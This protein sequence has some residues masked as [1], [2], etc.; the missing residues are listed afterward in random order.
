ME[1]AHRLQ[2]REFAAKD[3]FVSIKWFT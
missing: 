2:K 1:M 3:E